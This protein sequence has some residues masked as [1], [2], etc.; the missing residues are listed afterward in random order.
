M[1][2][3]GQAVFAAQA[4][5]G[6][7]EVAA[8]MDERGAQAAVPGLCGRAFDAR[9]GP[10]AAHLVVVGGALEAL[11][12]QGDGAAAAGE[13]EQPG[14]LAGAGFLEHFDAASVAFLRHGG[15]HAVV[16][17]VDHAADDAAA[18]DQ[19]G[20]AAL[21]LDLAR[22][23]GLQ[24]DGV[25]GAGGGGVLHLAAVREDAHARPVGAADHRPA[26]AG[27]VAAVAHAG[28]A[29]QRVAQ[30]AGAAL[31]QGAFVQQLDRGGRF[32][33]RNIE[34]GAGDAHGVEGGHGVAG[35]LRE[36]GR[37][38][39]AEG[40][41]QCQ[42]AARVGGRLDHDRCGWRWMRGMRNARRNGR[43]MRHAGTLSGISARARGR[44]CR[45]RSCR[46]G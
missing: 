35:G 4:A 32:L 40:A 8:R 24:S 22:Q 10:A 13:R 12:V 44:P 1:A 14:A 20:G 34:R 25:V 31:Q 2:V 41:G 21:D 28:Q 45:A 7:A 23:H 27:A 6:H 42:R 17:H 37:R 29:V 11:D 46:R 16:A 18:V 30:R 36:C 19:R 3:A 15:G 38:Q 33:Q 26:R 5:V 9:R 39:R 43:L